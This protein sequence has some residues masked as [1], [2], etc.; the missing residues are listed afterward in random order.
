MY[1]HYRVK[2]NKYSIICL[3]ETYLNLSDVNA[4]I[5]FNVKGYTLFKLY[6]QIHA[7]GVL[8][9][10]KY[11]LN[12]LRIYYSTSLDVEYIC[13]DIDICSKNKIR[14][15]YFIDNLQHILLTTK[16]YVT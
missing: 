14:I 9:L 10:C 1:Q 8:I 11:N 4:F 3:V 2:C 16:K 15:L 7:G 13:L 6:K 5:I 12:P